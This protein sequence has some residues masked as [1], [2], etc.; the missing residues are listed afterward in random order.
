MTSFQQPK[1]QSVGALSQELKARGLYYFV[2]YG[3]YLS[4][5]TLGGSP[6]GVTDA[7]SAGEIG[8]EW[9]LNAAFD[10]NG[11]GIPDIFAR[12]EGGNPTKGELRIFYGDAQGDYR[13]GEPF[14]P[15]GVEWQLQLFRFRGGPVYLFGHN[16]QNGD[17]Q[18]W[19]MDGYKIIGTADNLGRIGLEWDLQ[20][21]YFGDGF[22]IDIMGVRKAGK[23]EEIGDIHVWYTG[24]RADGKWGVV[25]DAPFGH[26][27]TEWRLQVAD[28]NGDGKDDVFGHT[29]NNDLWVWYNIDN[30]VGG[31]CL[32]AGHTYGK[33]GTEWQQL[34]VAYLDDDAYPDILAQ[35]DQGKRRGYYTNG[36]RITSDTDLSALDNWTP[37]V[38]APQRGL[39]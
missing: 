19:F 20:L 10:F 34:Q 38:G 23:P 37:I 21:G 12:N 24:L 7:R 8:V 13:S 3:K 11:D 14:G 28:M 35:S 2:R 39:V 31:R 30:G 18:A 4:K 17:I 25:R 26:I 22:Y 16:H 29:A 9:K 36:Q 6:F 27:G 5:L 15:I 1:E 32:N 33:L